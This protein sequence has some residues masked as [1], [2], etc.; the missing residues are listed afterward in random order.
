MFVKTFT[1]KVPFW[2]NLQRPT[3]LCVHRNDIIFLL[4]KDVYINYSKVLTKHGIGYVRSWDV[5]ND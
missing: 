3:Y 2:N 5:H 4:K 1:D